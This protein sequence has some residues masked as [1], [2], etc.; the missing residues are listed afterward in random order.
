MPWRF[1]L[2][3][4]LILLESLLTTVA[5]QSVFEALDAHTNARATLLEVII[6]RLDAK[7]TDQSDSKDH[8]LKSN[9]LTEENLLFLAGTF[10]NH[11]QF[12]LSDEN[13]AA[14]NGV[15]TAKT[16]DLQQPA[17][18]LVSSVFICAAVLQWLHCF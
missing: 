6:A 7:E 16:T 3:F 5:L 9:I 13:A 1:S 8:G 18:V 10:Q 11:T 15:F 14:L 4:R 2:P 12:L 17:V